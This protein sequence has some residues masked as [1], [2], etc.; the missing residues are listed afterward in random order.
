MGMGMRRIIFGLILLIDGL[1]RLFSF[2]IIS[3]VQDI[4]VSD[5]N[6]NKIWISKALGGN[7]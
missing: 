1:V 3:L 5:E 7:G 2:G 4:E 6:G